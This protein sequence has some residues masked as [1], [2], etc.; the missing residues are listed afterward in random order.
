MKP[1]YLAAL[2]MAALPLTVGLTLLATGGLA[3]SSHPLQAV[4]SNG[5]VT[6]GGV[7]RRGT[8]EWGAYD[9][10]HGHVGI[11]S[12]T[13]APDGV[14][15]V[16]LDPVG[17]AIGFGAVTPD[18]SMA[19]K[20]ITVGVSASLAELRLFFYRAGKSLSCDS[21]LFRDRRMNAWMIW[22]QPMEIQATE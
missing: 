4:D 9:P 1:R 20:G 19:R 13:C 2:S 22:E 21:D 8:G 16:A 6:I 3:R 11:S 5:L 12:V 10:G 18:E 17:V 14:L 15:H 7:L